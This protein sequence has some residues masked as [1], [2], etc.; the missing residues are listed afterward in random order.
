LTE[1]TGSPH[2]NESKN[3]NNQYLLT[4]AR[5]IAFNTTN[6]D[7]LLIDGNELN[8]FQSALVY[9]I[10]HEI[11]HISHGHL[12]FIKSE[13]YQQFLDNEENKNLTLKTLEMDADC[14]GT[15]CAIDVSERYIRF[16]KKIE[17][18]PAGK[19]AEESVKEIRVDYILGIYIAQIFQDCLSSLTIPKAY[20]IG[21]AR[22]LNS[23][24]TLEAVSKL[25]F[26]ESQDLL[27]EVR[28][29]L[30]Q[31]FV[32]LSGDLQNLQHPIATN[33]LIVE[34]DG[35]PHFVYDTL[36]EAI[37]KASLDPLYSRW[38]RIRPM[39]EKYQRGGRLA[40]AVA[41]PF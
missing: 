10:G 34:N 26:P 16:F 23:V 19:S 30:V 11:A 20:P 21:Y 41:P 31:C 18:Y 32:N 8:V 33:S 38:S 40:P 37:I 5:D 6:V 35:T 39:L 29:A 14:S 25:H 17:Q 12:E 4:I 7:H 3:Y 1:L 9:I 13:D 27:L 22:F 24:G 28:L 2:I 15:T 36:T